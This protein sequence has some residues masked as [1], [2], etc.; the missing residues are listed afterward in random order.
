MII[1]KHEFG[2]VIAYID[3]GSG[4]VMLQMLGAAVLGAW[5]YFRRAV[6]RFAGRLFGRNQQVAADLHSDKPENNTA[7]AR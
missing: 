5:F 2:I 3:P 6:S 1:P 7:E 4:L